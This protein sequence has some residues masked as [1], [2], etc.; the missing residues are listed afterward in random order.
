MYLTTLAQNL[1]PTRLPHTDGKFKGPYLY[2]VYT[3]RGE[4]VTQMLM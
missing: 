1:I 3:G 4:G 2:D